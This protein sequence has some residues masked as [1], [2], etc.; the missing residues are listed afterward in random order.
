M[1][2]RKQRGT[3]EEKKK[4]KK[5]EALAETHGMIQCAVCDNGKE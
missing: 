1:I 4:K 2:M 3:L 5:K